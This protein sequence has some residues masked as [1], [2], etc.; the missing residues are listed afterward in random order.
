MLTKANFLKWQVC[1]QAYLT[2]HDHVRVL[3]RTWVAARGWI[4]PV[5]PTDPKELEAWH[6]SERMARGIIVST[7]VDLHLELVH[8]H[9][10]GSP[11]VLWLAIEAKHVRQD[12]SFWHAAWMSLL[13]S[14]AM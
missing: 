13:V 5:A 12:A 11:W 7:V 1:V 6:H 4:D 10:Q 8:K 3:E 9:Q 14:L 2:P